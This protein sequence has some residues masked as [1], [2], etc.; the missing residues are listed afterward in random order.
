MNEVVQ[1]VKEKY[2]QYKDVPDDELTLK[3]A[4]Q[5]PQYLSNSSFNQDVAR[6]RSRAEGA[7]VSPLL[8]STNLPPQFKPSEKQRAIEEEIISA[9]QHPFTTPLARP[10]K[11]LADAGAAIGYRIGQR[12]VFGVSGEDEPPTVKEIGA[13]PLSD[14]TT[15]IISGAVTGAA[16]LGDFFTSPLGIATLGI[17]A[18]PVLV[19]RAV[20]LTFATQMATHLPQIATELGAELGKPEE[21]RDYSKISQL[22]TE[23]AA[24]TA[25]VAMG[26]KHGIGEPVANM[27]GANPTIV[28]QT[29]AL[30]SVQALKETTKAN[31]QGEPPQEIR[32]ENSETGVG[33]ERVQPQ[34]S[35][36]SVE[37]VVAKETV[38]PKAQEA[39]EIAS[40]KEMLGL[41]GAVPS[42]F[43]NKPTTPT[44]IKNATVDVE[45]SKRGLPPAIEPARKSFGKVWDEAMARIDHDPEYPDRLIGELRDKP[46]ALTDT[47]DAVL[48]QRQ[49]DLQ[50]EYGKATR[51]LAQAHDDG[52]V[53][54]VELE[55]ARVAALSDQLLDLYDV[56]KK[57]GTET[58]RG[59]NAR[60]MMA[61]EDFSLANMEMQARA[62]KGGRQLT[63]AERTEVT[64]ANKKI[65]STQQAFDEYVAK[66]DKALAE[67][68]MQNALDE[69]QADVKAAKVKSPA[70][71]ADVEG[72]QADIK[73]KIKLRLDEGQR[74][75]ISSLVQKLARMFVEQGVSGRDA[76]IDAVHGVLKE[77]DPEFTRR[78]TMDAIS[79]YGE[80]KQLTKD[81]IS[82]KLRDLK[83][84]M[85][86]VAKLEDMQAGQPPMKTGVERRIPST[87]ESRLI[88][89][90][91][92]AKNQFQ[93]PITDEA[94]Q[95]KSSLDTL[96]TRLKRQIADWED[97]L[98]RSDFAK[99]QKRII[100]MDEEANRLHF[101]NAE[102]KA[103]WHEALMKDRLANRS[104]PQKVFG[105]GA[106]TANTFRALKTSFDLSAVLRQGGFIAFGRPVTAIKA[107]PAMF[108]GLMSKEGQHAVNREIMARKNYALYK[109]S[110]LYLAE[111]GQKL[112]QME[113]AYMSRW[114]EHIPI[115]AASERAYT[116]FL[117]RLRADTFD[118]LANTLSRSG[119]LTPAEGT[120]LANYINVA[121]GR[122]SI[123]M[124][125]GAMVGLNTVFFSPRFVA[126]RFQLVLGQPL[127]RGTARTRIAVAKEYGRFMIG[128]GTVYMIGNMAGAS[129]ELDPRSAD[130][131]KMKFGNTR[132][133]PLAGIAQV[134][135]LLSRLAI[136]ETKSTK[137]KVTPIRGDKVP[138]GSGN[139][140]DVI[141]RFLRS[142]LSPAVGTIVNVLTGKNVVGQPVTP[143][144]TAKDLLVPMAFSD[145]FQVMKEQG[146]PEDL[147]IA[148]LAIFGMSVQNYKDGKR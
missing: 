32:P 107:L 82:V 80:F 94:T 125:D 101:A 6:L 97:R 27:V 100:Q 86:Q 138:F 35:N 137:G 15:K 148:L 13:D 39:Q 8:S 123:G 53:E 95:L 21:E 31:E 56:G 68:D 72:Q 109:Q 50:N 89:L 147:I 51:D 23:A 2:S 145:I 126:S 33:S 115:V 61:Y 73:Q 10:I 84:Q 26:V 111:H 103:K 130:F 92:E 54:D 144:S 120:A 90:V 22:T 36:E 91:N 44:G 16:E 14:K 102:A 121:T 12:E 98:A 38:E 9:E 58:G 46:R 52:R 45:R 25:F 42:E 62:S 66:T 118:I 104:V 140:Y 55:K 112:S 135:T 28:K 132:V 106:E 43:E 57:V 78:E 74:S 65:I 67:R 40:A 128:L 60:K 5:Y 63:D 79:G 47:E 3:L 136:G 17:G 49:I 11:A 83:G 96:K 141:A 110:K 88:R 29:L 64:E 99:K 85:Q 7:T 127:Y 133:D 41:G 70:K 77:I 20:A 119:E 75:D 105:A 69:M 19:Q 116:T 37:Q 114:A 108:R 1:A 139:S 81:E 59:L 129:I 142:K 124:R 143:A 117:N 34:T 76:L 30:R 4:D 93:I 18:M 24:S 71:P 48:L 146:T 87:E 113:E 122:G 134:T 131:G